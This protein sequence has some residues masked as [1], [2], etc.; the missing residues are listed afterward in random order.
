[1]DGPPFHCDA[2][3]DNP[4]MEARPMQT[5]ASDFVSSQS[6]LKQIESCTADIHTW[7]C[8]V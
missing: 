8:Q 2:R 3:I 4:N 5:I 7:H 6:R 1:M